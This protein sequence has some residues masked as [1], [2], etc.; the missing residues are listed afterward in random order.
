[1]KRL[2]TNQCY[3]LSEYIDCKKRTKKDITFRD[4][5]DDVELVR[6]MLENSSQTEWDGER[7]LSETRQAI[8]NMCKKLCPG[9]WCTRGHC[10]YCRSGHAYNCGKGTRPAVCKDFKKWRECQKERA[11]KQKG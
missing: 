5:K 7:S 4:G 3:V 6:F 2:G 9:E 8:H 10:M 11:S 1:M